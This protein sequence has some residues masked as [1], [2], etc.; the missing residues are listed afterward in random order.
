MED[1]S[2]GRVDGTA[3]RGTAARAQCGICR[4]ADAAMA[5]L[6]RAVVKH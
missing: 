3:A 4:A 2:V 1:G 6:E 5:A